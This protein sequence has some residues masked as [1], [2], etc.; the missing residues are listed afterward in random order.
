[1][2]CRAA[3]LAGAVLDLT[4]PE[5]HGHGGRVSNMI[6]HCKGQG[7]ASPNC[8]HVSSGAE[9]YDSVQVCEIWVKLTLL[10]RIVMFCKGEN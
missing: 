7:T 9:I 2:L 10:P 8:L 1:M 5:Q 6:T 3:A 4:A